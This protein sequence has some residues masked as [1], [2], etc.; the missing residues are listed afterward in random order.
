MKIMGT[1]DTTITPGQCRAARRLLAFTQAEFAE[2]AKVSLKTL[3]DFEAGRGQHKCGQVGAIRAALEAAGIEFTGEGVRW[4]LPPLA[5]EEGSHRLRAPRLEAW[6]GRLGGEGG[7]AVDNL[8]S[9]TAN[10]A[11]IAG[12]GTR[13][14][15]P[16][17]DPLSPDFISAAR[18]KN[19][20]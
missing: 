19:R 14:P 18:R 5:P 8:Q 2:A 9:A 3:R 20:R 4:T 7:A 12:R 15:E 11:R 1:T 13:A 10:R 6:P 17:P 16:A